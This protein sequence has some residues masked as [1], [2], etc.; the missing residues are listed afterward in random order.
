VAFFI[1]DHA[2]GVFRRGV[3]FQNC[4][5]GFGV[6]VVRGDVRTLQG[7]FKGVVGGACGPM[8]SPFMGVH[9]LPREPMG[10]G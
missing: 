5:V 3:G 8:V 4:F 6:L 9:L 7:E 10:I 1:A 2:G